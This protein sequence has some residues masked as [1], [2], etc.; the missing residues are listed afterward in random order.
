[1]TDCN[2][3]PLGQ[4]DLI[5]CWLH[6]DDMEEFMKDYVKVIRCNDCGFQDGCKNA[7]YLGVDGYCSNALPKRRINENN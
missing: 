3:C 4:F 5:G 1:M 6:C 7:Q 2:G